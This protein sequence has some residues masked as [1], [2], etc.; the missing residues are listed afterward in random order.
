[1]TGYSENKWINFAGFQLV[2]WLSILF[3]NLAIGV[4]LAALSLHFLFHS[5]PFS[6]MAT[7]FCAAI[8]GFSI[9]SWLTLTGFF[10]FDGRDGIPP[11]WLFMLWMGFAATLRQSLSFF[12]DRYMLASALGGV[13]GSSTYIAAAEL[14]AV[15]LDW[16][17][18]NS[19]LA[20]TIVWS[21]LFPLLVFLSHL[22]SQ[23]YAS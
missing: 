18:L 19:F 9:D 21:F 4:A 16:G 22:L 5:R 17:L 23:R 8:L 1:M 6:E 3:G 13:G 20:L 14:G 11:L 12:T 15:Q 7:V 10:Q 2:W